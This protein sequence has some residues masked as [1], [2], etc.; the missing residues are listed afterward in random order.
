MPSG[1]EKFGSS[2]IPEEDGPYGE[3]K[4]GAEEL[5]FLLKQLEALDEKK[6]NK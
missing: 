3:N 4:T 1:P 6:D 2:G 5:L